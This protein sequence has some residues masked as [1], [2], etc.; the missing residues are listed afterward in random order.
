MKKILLI[1]DDEDLLEL[2]A[3]VLKNEKYYVETASNG[4]EGLEKFNKTKFDLVILDIR[5]PVMDGIETL[6]AILEQR[7][8]VKIIINTAYGSYKDNFLTWAAD[9]Y[10]IKSSSLDDLLKKVKGL[11]G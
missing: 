3:E 1:E 4:R 5:M 7:K 10:L 2:Y 9:A 6:G 11:I 8:D